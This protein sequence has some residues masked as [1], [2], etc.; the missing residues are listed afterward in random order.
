MESEGKVAYAVYMQKEE[1]LK[2]QES[3]LLLGERTT[4]EEK[5]TERLYLKS[6]VDKEKKNLYKGAF[7]SLQG[8]IQVLSG[9][10]KRLN[11]GA[12]QQSTKRTL[13]ALSKQTRYMA[14]AYRNS[15]PACA[16][17]CNSWAERLDGAAEQEIVYVWQLRYMLCEACEGY[18]QL[19]KAFCL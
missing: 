4:V 1:A 8:C 11:D 9:E 7:Q 2:A 13:N 5:T 12:T 19:T 10:V 3:L 18:V 16:A 6:R 17:L 14:E 15:F